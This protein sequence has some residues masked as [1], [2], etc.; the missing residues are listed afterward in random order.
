[1]ISVCVIVLFVCVGVFV[2]IGVGGGGARVSA[3]TCVR[4]QNGS[5]S[6]APAHPQILLDVFP[7]LCFSF[8]C[9]HACPHFVARH[10]RHIHIVFTK[11]D[12][13]YVFPTEV[14]LVV[15]S[16]INFY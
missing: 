13:I 1:M 10:G 12:Q 14:D 3:C 9:T 4:A 16:L 5:F 7:A 11:W 6:P 2:C 15:Y 8:A